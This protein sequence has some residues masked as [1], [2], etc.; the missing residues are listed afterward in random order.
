MINR[1]L[2]YDGIRPSPFGGKLSQSQ[3][4]GIE[5]VLNFWESPP[6][7]PDGD[8]GKQWGIRAPGWL[9]Y[10]LATI[11]HETATKMQPISEYGS[12]DYFTKHYET[13]SDLGNGPAAG[14]QAGD[15]A[16]FHGRG[17]VQL[18]GRRNYTLMVPI[19]RHFYPDCPDFT[20]DPEA[21][22]Q[23]DYA[24]TI[25]FYGMFCGTFTGRALKHYIGDASARQGVDFVGARHIINGNDRAS[26]IAGYAQ[27]FMA[28]LD[29]SMTAVHVHHRGER[30]T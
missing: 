20:T 29:S 22:K 30:Q 27:H 14:G 1:K 5:A 19:V 25:L 8:F 17:F 16:R 10:M 11:Y 13:R 12:N 23:L 4:D 21:V 6:V 28:A 3:V 9:A 7:N 2:F 24:S 15:G 18:T 26:T